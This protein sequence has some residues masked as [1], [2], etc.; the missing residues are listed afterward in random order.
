MDITYDIGIHG[1]MLYSWYGQRS[2]RQINLDNNTAVQKNDAAFPLTWSID[3]DYPT[4]KSSSYWGGPVTLE[5][6]PCAA[7][8]RA[9]FQ[10]LRRLNFPWAGTLNLEDLVPIMF[11]KTTRNTM[12]ESTL[13]HKLNIYAYIYIYV[14]IYI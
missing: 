5:T 9:R 12:A 8:P 6:P 4:D 1:V 11:S 10:A 7:D 14:Y 13:P 3:K 2:F